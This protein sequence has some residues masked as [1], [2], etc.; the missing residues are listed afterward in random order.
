[1]LIYGEALSLALEA[2]KRRLIDAIGR[3]PSREERSKSGVPLFTAYE[4]HQ[5]EL[6]ALKK[7]YLEDE[8]YRVASEAALR[9]TISRNGAEWAELRSRV[10]ERDRGMCQVC[11]ENVGE[12]YECGHIIDRVIGGSD[13]LSN[14]V[15]MCVVCNRLKPLTETRAEYLA[16][17]SQGG[18]VKEVTAHVIQQSGIGTI[19]HSI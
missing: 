16:W 12:N 19:L 4:Q 6:T 2:G 3:L 15:C 7:R 17:A 1:L 9:G 8:P 5:V 18:P 13:R 10:W 14:L 11:G